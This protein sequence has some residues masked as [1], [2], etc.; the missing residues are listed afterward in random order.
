MPEPGRLERALANV[1]VLSD[2]A[3]VAAPVR[4]REGLL[5]ARLV[6]QLVAEDDVPRL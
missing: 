2:R 6:A 3:R 4:R 1:E 5:T